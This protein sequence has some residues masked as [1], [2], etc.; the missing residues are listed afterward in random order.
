MS[1]RFET[2][3]IHDRHEPDPNLGMPAPPIYPTAAFRGGSLD[4]PGPIACSRGGSATRKALES[5]LADRHSS[6]YAYAFGSG[7]GAVPRPFDRCLLPRGAHTLAL[8]MARHPGNRHATARGLDKQPCVA[9]AHHP[10]L[11]NH[12]S[13]ALAA[14]HRSGYSGMLS[15]ALAGV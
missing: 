11:P 13:Q 2:R 4:E 7:T 15:F 9:R 14:S 6:R 5:A 3:A 8:R 12:P 1:E 10:G